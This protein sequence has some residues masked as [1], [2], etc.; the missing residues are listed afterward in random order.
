[1]RSSKVNMIGHQTECDH[2]T[3]MSR[4]LGWQESIEVTQLTDTDHWSA[5]K[6]SPYDMNEDRAWHGA[7]V[8]KISCMSQSFQC[9]KCHIAVYYRALKRQIGSATVLE[10]LE[11]RRN[12][13][14]QDNPQSAN[15]RLQPLARLIPPA[16]TARPH[17]PQKP[18]PGQSAAMP[19]AEAPRE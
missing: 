18:L 11:R 16:A 10:R 12:T 7:R 8:T 1:M 6:S 3:A 5:I 4:C 17:S 9:G 19:L 2:L 15:Q 13:L 14:L